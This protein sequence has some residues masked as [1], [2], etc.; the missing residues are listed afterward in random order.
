MA[1][2]MKIVGVEGVRRGKQK[3]VTTLRDTKAPRH[4]DLIKRNWGAPTP[5]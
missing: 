1:R 5:P 3:T 2:L 4:P